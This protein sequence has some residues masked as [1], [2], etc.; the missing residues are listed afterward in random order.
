LSGL[1]PARADELLERA[2]SV[3]VLVVGDVML[4]RYVSGRVERV[5]P[6]APVPVVVVEEER[7]SLGGAGNVA[8]NVAALG[9]ACAI[10]GCV[11][12]DSA[13]SEV[14]AEMEDRGVDADGV[15]RVA[16]RPTTVKTRV[17]AR[18]Q[19]IV[20]LDREVT[21]DV[22]AAVEAELLVAI[23]ERAGDIDAVVIQDYDKGVMTAGMAAAI[24]EVAAER[25]IPLV[26]D[27]K[28]RAFFGYSGASVFKPNRRELEDALGE[29]VRP[30]DEEWMDSVRRRVGCT[31]LLVTLGDR[32]MALQT[33]N[34]GLIRLAAV[35]SEVYDVSGAGDTVSATLAV[36]MAAGATV[37][38][39]AAL[40]NHAAAVEVQRPGVRTVTRT[41]IRQH[42]AA[43]PEPLQRPAETEAP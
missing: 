26:V 36:A 34:G 1:D 31:D 7:A 8:A 20:R 14:F 37:T 19:Q 22:D 23:R 28:R 17:H 15:A 30:D 18:P 40:A 3:R 41:D 13:G 16:S 6:E 9:A 43:R 38:E 12:D 25:T 33:E 5:S 32:G 35:A 2:G 10:V 11:G 21:H 29:A 4:D 42:L 24:L 27:P 39:A